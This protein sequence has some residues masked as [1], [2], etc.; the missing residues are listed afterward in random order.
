MFYLPAPAASLFQDGKQFEV[1]SN[2]L[3]PGG[4]GS[5]SGGGGQNKNE[6]H[7]LA[8]DDDEELPNEVCV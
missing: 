5:N 7:S 6:N 8:F 2:H 3:A 1:V 4:G